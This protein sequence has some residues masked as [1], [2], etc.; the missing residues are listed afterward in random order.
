MNKSK[1]RLKTQ[2]YKVLCYTSKFCRRDREVRA[3]RA[4]SA[5]FEDSLDIRRLVD[6]RFKLN[7]LIDTLL[8]SNQ[9]FLFFNQRSKVVQLDHARDLQQKDDTSHYSIWALDAHQQNAKVVNKA[10]LKMLGSTTKD[11]LEKK[12]LL[13]AL[14][15]L[16][17]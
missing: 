11:Q 15:L 8:T 5:V 16:Q 17:E 10:I 2:F 9:R 3:Q 13:G 14:P 6:D 4:T 7:L 1:K 12:L